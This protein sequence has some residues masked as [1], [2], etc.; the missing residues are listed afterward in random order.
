MSEI[1]KVA[2][3]DAHK[4]ED[5]HP[6][7]K[8]FLFLGE[9]KVKRGFIVLPFVGMIITIILGMIYPLKHPAPWE[10]FPGSWAVFGFIAYSLIVFAA[11]PLFKL[12]ARD[13]TYYGEGGLPDPFYS[14]EHTH[15]GEH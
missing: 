11:K 6:A 3:I 8:P 10:V 2:E 5:I 4:A 7:A 15:E 12:L 9:E 1:D 13:E 14:T